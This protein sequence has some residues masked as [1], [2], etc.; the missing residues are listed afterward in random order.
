MELRK[1]EKQCKNNL[2]R[3]G[4][5]YNV[6]KNEETYLT[7]K[8]QNEVMQSKLKA[9]KSKVQKETQEKE[10]E[11]LEKEKLSNKKDKL[12]K[13][14]FLIRFFYSN[15]I[16]ILYELETIIYNKLMQQ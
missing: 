11:K 9:E 2:Q 10:N 4:I 13:K 3:L 5:R 16:K 14:N 12:D 1:L 8:N 6:L 7:F 15:E